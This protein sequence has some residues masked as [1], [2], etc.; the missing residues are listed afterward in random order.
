MVIGLHPEPISIFGHTEE[1][2][3]RATFFSLL[4]FVHTGERDDGENVDF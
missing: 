2:Q 1:V 4:N 3:P